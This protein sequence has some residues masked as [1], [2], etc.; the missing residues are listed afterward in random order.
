[1]SMQCWCFCSNACGVWVRMPCSPGA[2]FQIGLQICLA[3]MRECAHMYTVRTVC[4]CAAAPQQNA[5]PQQQ[6]PVCGCAQAPQ[7]Q[8]PPVCPGTTSC[9]QPANTCCQQ[10]IQIPMPAPMPIIQQPSKQMCNAC[11]YS[12]NHCVSSLFCRAHCAHIPVSACPGG[13]TPI[14]TNCGGCP[15]Y[16]PCQ[17]GVG[18]CQPVQQIPCMCAAACLN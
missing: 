1:M 10:Q 18:C 17:Q 9:Q 3:P 4:V 5:C 15:A 6:A 2:T 16:A 12:Y 8:A 14:S 11:I 13:L 7:I